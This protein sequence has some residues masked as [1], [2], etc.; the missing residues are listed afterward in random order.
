MH[1]RS[2]HSGQSGHGQTSFCLWSR[3]S[4]NQRYSFSTNFKLGGGWGATDLRV[5]V[6][7]LQAEPSNMVIGGL[8]LAKDNQSFSPIGSNLTEVV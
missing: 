3:N 5:R 4:K 2:T 7:V 8:N 1:G 6:S